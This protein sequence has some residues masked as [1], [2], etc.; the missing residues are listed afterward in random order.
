MTVNTKS[1]FMHNYLKCKDF[2]NGYQASPYDYG[3]IMHLPTRCIWSPW[4]FGSQ[5]ITISVY[6]NTEYARQGQPT[7]EQR[8]LKTS[9]RQ[10]DC[11][12]AHA[13][14]IMAL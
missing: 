14:L 10:T 13:G 6:N 2:E 9:G 8:V 4:C 5:C 11:A 3:S 7:L 1:R 12:C